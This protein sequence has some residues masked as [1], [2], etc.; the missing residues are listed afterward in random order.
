[1]LEQYRAQNEELKLTK[2]FHEEMTKKHVAEAAK[3]K[4]VIKEVGP[5]V[6]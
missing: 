4:K 2:E 6:L 3:H 1:M 5:C